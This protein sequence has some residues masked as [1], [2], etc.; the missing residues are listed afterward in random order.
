MKKLIC[1][2]LV[3]TMMLTAFA[4]CSK[5]KDNTAAS[6]TAAAEASNSTIDSFN[7]LGDIMNS[8]KVEFA[9]SGAN[10]ETYIYVF[11]LD[12]TYYRALAIM[13]QDVQ[14]ALYALEVDKP[15]YD[16]KVNELVS[17]LNIEK[18]ENISKQII[19]QAELDKYVGKTLGDLMNEGWGSSGSNYEEM[20]FMFNKGPFVYA[21]KVEGKID[22]IEK[23][24]ENEEENMKPFVI[25]SLAFSDLGDVTVLD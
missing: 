8:N 3:L 19:P 15:N 11:T 20:E 10:G 17:P 7:I 14:D 16:D 24:Q 9:G 22:N 2:I 18:C 12:G 23:F 21:V 6:A 4:A 1:A 13:P 25:K 5:S